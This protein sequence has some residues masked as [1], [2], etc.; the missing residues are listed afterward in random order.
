MRRIGRAESQRGL[1]G[2]G[3]SRKRGLVGCGW[4]GLGSVGCVWAESTLP[5]ILARQCCRR[6]IRRAGSS[7]GHT[8]AKGVHP[9]T[10]TTA[11]TTLGIPTQLP[12]LRLAAKNLSLRKVSC[13]G[14]ILLPLLC[15]GLFKKKS[16]VM[17]R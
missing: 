8:A 9:P 13:V 17:K 4:S 11:T 1:A 12:A 10:T 5:A 3:S 6:R 7:M 2:R 16:Q 14:V 15:M